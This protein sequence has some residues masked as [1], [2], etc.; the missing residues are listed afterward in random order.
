MSILSR[1]SVGEFRRWELPEVGPGANAAAPNLRTLRQLEDIDQR[2]REEGFA[3]GLAEGRLAGAAEIAAQVARIS[4]I[5]NAL[6]AP[7]ANLDRAVE[8]ELVLVATVAATRIV[9]HEIALAPERILDA[10]RDAI[11]A[12]PGYAR[13][14]RL[15]LTPDDAAIV[16][17]HLASSSSGH[18]WEIVEDAS[19]T[20]GG[21]RV[22]A[23][24]STVD[25]TLETRLA[26][27]IDALLGGSAATEMPR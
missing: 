14:V 13:N 8:N 6:E 5:V 10:V 15:F 17:G 20:A 16:R 18:T 4:A 1:E 2:A 3:S 26:T 7:F 25:A 23:D 11:A 24:T 19:L 21:C 27:I 12:L 9:R 22:Q